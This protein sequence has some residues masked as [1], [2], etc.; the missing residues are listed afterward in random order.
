[1]AGPARAS[2]RSSKLSPSRNRAAASRSKAPPSPS[3]ESLTQRLRSAATLALNAVDELSNLEEA[4]RA[5]DCLEALIAPF[6]PL[7]STEIPVNRHELSALLL[8]V[9]TELKRRVEAADTAV[10]SV[11]DE[12]AARDSTA[13]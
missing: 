9:N 12:L 3:A 11:H 1:M 5:Y 10:K 7:D 4:R 13:L 8:L 2:A 6:K